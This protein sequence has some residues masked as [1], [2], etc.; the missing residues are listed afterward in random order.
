VYYLESGAEDNGTQIAN[1]AANMAALANLFEPFK[2]TV[3]RTGTNSEER[4][5]YFALVT[6]KDPIDLDKSSR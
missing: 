2:S 1:A 4:L 3:N 5:G 6:G